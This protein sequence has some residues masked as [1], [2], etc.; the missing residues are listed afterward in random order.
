[1][2]MQASHADADSGPGSLFIEHDRVK[3]GAVLAS[4]I[5]SVPHAGGVSNHMGSLMTRDPQAMRWFMLSLAEL[6]GLFFLDSYTTHPSVG[7]MTARE[8]GSENA[9]QLSY[10][11][12]IGYA[13]T[14]DF[15][16]RH[17]M[18]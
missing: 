16:A 18:H 7:L 5:A 10:A 15:V 9:R 2:P 4:A 1:M 12:S 11:E 3:V 14:S 8:Y 13:P 17:R 6:D